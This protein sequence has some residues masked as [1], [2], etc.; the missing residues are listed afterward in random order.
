MKLY[1]QQT[2]LFLKKVLVTRVTLYTPRPGHGQQLHQY[3]L[4]LWS[5]K[6]WHGKS[7]TQMQDWESLLFLLFHFH[8]IH[9]RLARNSGH[10]HY[11]YRCQMANISEAIPDPS[12]FPWCIKHRWGVKCILQWSDTVDYLTE[13]AHAECKNLCHL[14]P[15]FFL[16]ST[17]GAWHQWIHIFITCHVA[18][19][20]Q[21]L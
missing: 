19:N 21:V 7:T 15:K 3:S 20:I 8:Q 13:I 5:Y 1:L 10:K 17:D 16:H 9:H 4:F 2:T 12:R 18:I 14:S 11:A 6:Q